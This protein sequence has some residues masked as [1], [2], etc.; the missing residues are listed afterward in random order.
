[1]ASRVSVKRRLWTG[2]VLNALVILLMAPYGR[3]LQHIAEGFAGKKIATVFTIIIIFFGIYL[4]YR[5]VF[6]TRDQRLKRL[7]IFSVV[8]AFYAWR[9]VTLD[10]QVERFH[11][12]EYGLLA[13]LVCLAAQKNSRGWSAFGWGFAAAWLIGLLDELFQWWWPTRVGEW[14]DVTINMQSGALGLVATALLFRNRL[15]FHKPSRSSIMVL[16]FVFSLLSLFSGQFILKVH[17]F[18]FQHTDPEIG[19]FYSF[20]MKKVL[21]ESTSTAYLQ[22]VARAGGH[23]SDRAI[24]DIFLY[25]YER[26]SKEHFDRVHLLLEQGRPEEARLEYALVNRYYA[27]WLEGTGASFNEAVMKQIESTGRADPEQFVSPVMN[28]MLV[29]VTRREVVGLTWIAAFLMLI[30]GMVTYFRLL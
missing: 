7:M 21:E 27:P 8:S 2:A 26:E 24:T 25:F 22:Q 19:T 4:F 18:G 23:Q 6:R 11:M 20:F 15:S 12:I 9:L 10:V 29:S 1:M 16:S 3:A 30:P 17:V 28:W 14:R 13:G 5:Y